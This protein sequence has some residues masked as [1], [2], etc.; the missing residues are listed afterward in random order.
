MIEEL[1]EAEVGRLFDLNTLL[2]RGSVNQSVLWIA[3]VEGATDGT[4]DDAV[5][6]ADVVQIPMVVHSCLLNCKLVY[7]ET[8]KC[9]KD[10]LL[11]ALSFVCMLHSW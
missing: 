8:V 5:T 4:S 6:V 1:S 3:E 11:T 9:P 7:V 10:E 2:Y